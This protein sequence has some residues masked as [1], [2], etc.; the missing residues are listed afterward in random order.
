MKKEGFNHDYK[1]ESRKRTHEK[2][3]FRMSALR[4]MFRKNNG[5][6]VEPIG[7]KNPKKP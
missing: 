2:R 3:V 7:R 1:K 5:F 4:R 6:H